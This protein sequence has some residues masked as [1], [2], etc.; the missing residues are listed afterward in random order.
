[1]TAMQ[2]AEHFPGA[3]KYVRGARSVGAMIDSARHGDL[4]A[5]TS[6]NML[7]AMKLVPGVGYIST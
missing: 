3:A 2:A 4:S 6:D 1:M 7:N 5:F